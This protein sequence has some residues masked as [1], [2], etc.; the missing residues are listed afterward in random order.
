[1]KGIIVNNKIF[2]IIQSEV[3]KTSSVRSHGSSISSN[4]N[5]STESISDVNTASGVS[6]RSTV[7]TEVSENHERK[8]DDVI[9]L[10]TPKKVRWLSLTGIAAFYCFSPIERTMVRIF[11]FLML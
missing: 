1:M 9:S 10:F 3:V 11:F 8:D 6:S 2:I 5:S 7:K 4:H